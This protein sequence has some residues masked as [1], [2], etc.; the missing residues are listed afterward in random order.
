M[1]EWLFPCEAI[2]RISWQPKTRQ[3]GEF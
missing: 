2:Q 1:M 3:T